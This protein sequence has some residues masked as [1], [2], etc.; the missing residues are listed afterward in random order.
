[1]LRKLY[2]ESTTKYNLNCKMCF[3]HTWFDELIWDLSLEDYRQVLATMPK[4]VETI[5][6]GGYLWAEGVLSCP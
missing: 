3:R 5:F 4:S 6:F 2:I 1:M